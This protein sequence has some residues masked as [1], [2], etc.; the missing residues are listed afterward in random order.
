MS[1]L[2]TLVFDLNEL[3]LGNFPFPE[4]KGEI[5]DEIIAATKSVS[6]PDKIDIL[7]KFSICPN[8]ENIRQVITFIPGMK[9]IQK[10]KINLLMEDVQC[11]Q[12]KKG[13]LKVSTLY[14]PPH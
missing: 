12:I 13:A 9:V 11:F 10:N 3:K 4:Q 7:C 2:I 6:T 5:F 1:S 14:L 8:N